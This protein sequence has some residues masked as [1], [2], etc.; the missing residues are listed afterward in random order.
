[1]TLGL[2]N[3]L[4]TEILYK[5]PAGPKKTASLFRD[6]DKDKFDDDFVYVDQNYTFYGKHALRTVKTIFA[7]G[8]KA[9]AIQKARMIHEPNKVI[10]RFRKQQK[11]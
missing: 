11:N 2:K 5:S 4:G 10:L 8:V 1:M 3:N 7:G 9:V 6:V